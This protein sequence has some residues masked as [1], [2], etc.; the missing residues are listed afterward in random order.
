MT[1]R[2]INI[3]GANILIMGLAFKENCP[4]IRNTKIY[5][6]FKQFENSNCKVDVYD[7]MVDKDE[8]LDKYNID[9]IDH[10]GVNKYDSIF[11]SF[12]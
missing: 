6:L 9:L 3:E 1:E 5:D 12:T 8:A 10:P 7:P 11:G 2:D 4:D